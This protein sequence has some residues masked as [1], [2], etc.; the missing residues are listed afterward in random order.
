MKL[1]HEQKEIFNFHFARVSDE[2]P[3]FT[4]TR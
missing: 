4:V 2:P 3:P 1:T